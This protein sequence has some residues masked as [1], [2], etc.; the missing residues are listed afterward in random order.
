MTREQ[1]RE[2]YESQVKFYKKSIEYSTNHIGFLTG[3][4]ERSR[5]EDRELVEWV[6]SRGVV[7]KFEMQ[8]YGTGKYQSTE[9]HKLLLERRREYLRRKKEEAKLQKYEK[10]LAN[11]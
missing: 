1:M 2:F 3:Q 9:T 7:D 11:A 10:L 8:I 6:W 5:K 4:L